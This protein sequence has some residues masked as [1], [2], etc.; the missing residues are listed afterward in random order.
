MAGVESYAA[1]IDENDV[2]LWM[3]FWVSERHTHSCLMEEGR[4]RPHDGLTD[5]QVTNTFYR[6]WSWSNNQ[7][8]TVR[9]GELRTS[10][11]R[12]NR[13]FRFIQTKLKTFL[14]LPWRW[15]E[16][17]WADTGSLKVAEDRK[18][19]QKAHNDAG[20]VGEM[21]CGSVCVPEPTAIPAWTLVVD[22]NSAR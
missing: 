16:V 22:R 20:Q 8:R 5:R 18:G 3:V 1:S 19:F 15:H 11:K 2:S 13:K 10:S 7:R 4:K 14:C 9:E 12:I 17:V 21:M 6:L